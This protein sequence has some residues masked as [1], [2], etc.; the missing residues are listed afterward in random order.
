MGLGPELG[1]RARRAD[2]AWVGGWVV[3]RRDFW[4]PQ[5]VPHERHMALHQSK[6]CKSVQ[7]GNE[8][9]TMQRRAHTL[10]MPSKSCMS[11]SSSSTI[12]SRSHSV[13]QRGRQAVWVWGGGCVGGTWR[14]W[15][16]CAKAA[17]HCAAAAAVK[18][19]QQ[20]HRPT[21]AGGGGAAAR[22]LGGVECQGDGDLRRGHHVHGDL[23]AGEDLKH[24]AAG[25]WA[26]HEQ[27]AGCCCHAQGP[28]ALH[29]PAPWLV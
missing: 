23:V 3:G 8:S 11:P 2:R 9:R 25:G 1:E 7:R 17:L 18:P 14:A 28:T 5:G 10:A 4:M 26:D 19:Q 24:L 12:R 22:S 20:R 16:V 6:Q 15:A 13:L 21:N 29:L 27:V